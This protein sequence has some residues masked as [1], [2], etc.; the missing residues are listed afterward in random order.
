MI[1][2]DE[3]EKLTQLAFE[4]GGL[5]G[6][7]IQYLLNEITALRKIAEAASVATCCYSKKCHLCIA[8]KEW[9]EG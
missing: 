9:R 7:T 3:H 6:A 4:I 8:Q 1:S 5:N 2:D